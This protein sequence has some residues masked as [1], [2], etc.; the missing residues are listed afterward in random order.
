[1]P[2]PVNCLQRTGEFRIILPAT[3]CPF[4]VREH[5]HANFDFNL[6]AVWQLWVPFE[7]DGP[8]VYFS[9]QYHT[10]PSSL[11]RVAEFGCTC[12]RDASFAG[13][14]P[15]LA[16]AT[17]ARGPPRGP[18][19]E[20]RAAAPPEPSPRTVRFFMKYAYIMQR[21]VCF[22][23]MLAKTAG[24]RKATPIPHLT[25][26]YAPRERR[27]VI[28]PVSRQSPPSPTRMGVRG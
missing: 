28:S 11:L 10:H 8:S 27:P 6:F 24:E 19:R 14:A 3:K 16:K 23:N 4:Q 1:M 26:V 13:K 7:F 12:R 18:Y 15:A 22:G 21:T 9:P 20:G 5:V 25:D 2:V 17:Q